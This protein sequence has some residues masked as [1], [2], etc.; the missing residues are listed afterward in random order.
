MEWGLLNKKGGRAMITD[1]LT[2]IHEQLKT[3]S[4]I[5]EDYVKYKD[6]CQQ[7]RRR[8]DDQQKMFIEA[9]AEMSE[10]QKAI[11][12]TVA[13]SAEF[14]AKNAENLQTVADIFT[15]IKTGRQSI[16]FIASIVGAVVIVAVTVTAAYEYFKSTILLLL[17]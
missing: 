2:P 17:H 11:C 12:F 10:S 15:S 14:D 3:H 16:P 1:E 13:K 6:E 5:L 9:L 7:H 8:S 4:T